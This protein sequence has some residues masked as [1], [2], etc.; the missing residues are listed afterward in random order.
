MDTLS[1]LVK[2]AQSGDLEA[3]EKIVKLFQ[4]M[5]YAI[6]YSMLNDAQLAEDVA[7]EAFIEAYLELPKLREP[8][9]FPGW[10]RRIV[11]KQS[12]RFTRGKHIPTIPL[13]Y[14]FNISTADFNVATI[15]EER[16]RDEL[17][18]KAIEA[19]SDNE[20]IVTLL[21]Y[22]T[23]YPLKEIATFLEVPV[24]TIKKRLHDAKRHLKESLIETVRDYL[25]EQRQRSLDHFS[26]KVQLLIAIRM[27]NIGRV[28]TIL[29]QNPWLVNAKVERNEC[30]T[31]TYTWIGNGLNP[32][33]E[34]ARN[35]NKTMVNLL[36]DY[37]AILQTGTYNALTIATQ[38]NHTDTVKLLLK[39][40]AEPNGRPQIGFNVKDVNL[41]PSPLRI[42]AMKGH[43][44]IVNLLLEQ[45]AIV[46]AFG[47]T[48]RTALHWASLKGKR[49]IVKMLLDFGADCSVQD[50][51]G[52]T[53]LDWA[54]IRNHQ[55]IAKQLQE[56]MISDHGQ[57]TFR[58]VRS[59]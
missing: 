11:F 54:L 4:D 40:G 43:Q 56:H 16:E 47:Q 49:D 51:L 50:E 25:H 58:G 21:F 52:R 7:Q 30:K 22:S 35:G 31:Q 33:Y 44:E 32:L 57:V 55:E 45:G 9:A 12:D 36:L 37:G 14:V 13:E 5:A 39:H 10:F 17:V 41:G 29:N 27:A 20:R 24:T 34:A 26:E 42:A 28:K 19:L 8:A 18:R 48:G 46:N 38:F 59:Q 15:I 2:S 3:F 6:A 53:P 1:T 23:G